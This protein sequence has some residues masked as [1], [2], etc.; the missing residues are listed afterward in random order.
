MIKI[1][2]LCDP[3]TQL[4]K[5][6]GLEEPAP[7]PSFGMVEQLHPSVAMIEP[8]PPQRASLNIRTHP[9]RWSTCK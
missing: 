2:A 9:P 1:C 3:N 6:I 7:H 8:D 4:Q 5:P